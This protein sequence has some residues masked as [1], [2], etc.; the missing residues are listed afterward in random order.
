MFNTKTGDIIQTVDI[1]TLVSW[2]DVAG[3]ACGMQ[4]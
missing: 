1:N 2:S 3:V 4:Q